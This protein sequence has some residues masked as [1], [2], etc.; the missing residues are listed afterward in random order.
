MLTIQP[1]CVT[2]NWQVTHHQTYTWETL[3]LLWI[4]G[5]LKGRVARATYFQNWHFLSERPISPTFAI[6]HYGQKVLHKNKE[7]F[8]E[9][10]SSTPRV[11]HLLQVCKLCDMHLP[12]TDTQINSQ[13]RSLLLV[14]IFT[15]LPKYTSTL[16]II[17]MSG[18][19]MTESM[20]MM[21]TA[22]MSLLSASA[23]AYPSSDH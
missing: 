16:V 9:T 18:I 19:S 20:T 23:A 1:I 13:P 14:T 6:M 11:S 2:F 10:L 15:Y 22:Q 12:L 7:M 17:N 21:M 5:K 4:S 3:S 8:C